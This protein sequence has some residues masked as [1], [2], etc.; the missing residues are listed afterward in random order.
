MDVLELYLHI[1]VVTLYKFSSVVKPKR[2]KYGQQG[3]SQINVS[4]T[5]SLSLSFQLILFSVMWRPQA[6]QATLAPSFHINV[7]SPHFLSCYSFSHFLF[8]LRFACQNSATLRA[9]G[10]TCSKLFPF[11]LFCAPLY[12]I[13]KSFNHTTASCFLHIFSAF[14]YKFY[15]V[16]HTS[17]TCLK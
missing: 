8:I 16:F 13:M 9:S 2:T 14:S 12:S 1:W 6:F 15:T 17:F 5:H 10:P 11:P 3:T 7:Y 4:A